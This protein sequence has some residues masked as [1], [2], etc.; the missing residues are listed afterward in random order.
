MYFPIR[1]DGLAKL[2]L[3]N[4]WRLVFDLKQRYFHLVD[5]LKLE[6]GGF[7]LDKLDRSE[8]SIV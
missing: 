7:R 6:E 8:K 5:P 3:A 2:D 4:V 1:S